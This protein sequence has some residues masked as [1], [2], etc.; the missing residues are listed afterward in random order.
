MIERRSFGR[1][2]HRSSVTLFGGAALSRVSQDE[3]DR[4]LEVL[5]RYGVNHIDT[6]ASYGESEVWLAP[7]LRMPLCGWSG[8]PRPGRR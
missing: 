4:T 1:T 5:L 2:G 7:W 6:A 3:A 8:S